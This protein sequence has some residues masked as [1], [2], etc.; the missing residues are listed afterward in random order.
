MCV[1]IILVH[2]RIHTNRDRCCSSQF[3][4]TNTVASLIFL[5]LALALS[6]LTSVLSALPDHPDV[7]THTVSNLS[8]EGGG[9]PASPP[10]SLSHTG[11]SFPYLLPHSLFLSLLPSVFPGHSCSDCDGSDKIYITVGPPLPP[12][13]QQAVVCNYRAA[14]S[15]TVWLVG[16]LWSAD[17]GVC[18]A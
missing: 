3:S 11:L 16:W 18:L 13:P 6:I 7:L 15:W 9:S 17:W 14:P 12:P 1:E 10:A 2:R 8:Q 4:V 5:S